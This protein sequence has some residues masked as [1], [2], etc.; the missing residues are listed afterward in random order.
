MGYQ[1]SSWQQLNL[2]PGCLKK[3]TIIHETLH[4]LGF[5]HQQSASNRDDY[6]KINF[7]NVKA[8][9]ENNFDKYPSNVVTDYGFGYDVASVMHYPAYAFSKNGKPTI[10]RRYHGNEVMGQREG[11]SQI[12]VAKIN[13][14]Y[15][16]R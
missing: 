3:G 9:T 15:C 8:G 7:N 14:M 4:A 11:L 6:I 10:E 16:G 12:D 2:S 1:R 13:K 5:F